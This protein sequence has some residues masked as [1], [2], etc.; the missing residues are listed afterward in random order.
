[1]T[2]PRMTDLDADNLLREF[3]CRE[4]VDRV[5][6]DVPGVRELLLSYYQSELNTLWVARNTAEA[7]EPDLR[8]LLRR[9]R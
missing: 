6:D 8:V 5:I 7:E 1:M 4:L 2:V 9:T 3:I